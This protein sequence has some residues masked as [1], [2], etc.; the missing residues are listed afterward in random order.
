[1]SLNKIYSI[2]DIYKSDETEYSQTSSTNAETF[3]NMYPSFDF[4]ANNDFEIELDYYST[5]NGGVCLNPTEQGTTI[6]YHLMYGQNFTQTALYWGD[7]SGTETAQRH[8]EQGIFNEYLH[9]KFIKN[10]NTISIYRD[11]V[12][13]DSVSNTELGKHGNIALGCGSWNIS[14]F[15]VKNLKVRLL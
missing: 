3:H 4:D 9:I 12:F 11:G 8:S 7:A 5:A 14:T 6:K 1:M 10:N 2:E 15:K 13:Y